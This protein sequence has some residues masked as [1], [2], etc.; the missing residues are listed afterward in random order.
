MHKNINNL[1]YS[2]PKTVD[3]TE[4][5]ADLDLI[6]IPRDRILSVEK[7]LSSEDVYVVFQASRILTSWG[8]NKGFGILVNFLKKEDFILT[9]RLHGYDETPQHIL[10]AL[11]RYWIN[12]SEVGL[13]YEAREKIQPYIKMII[14]MASQKG[15]QL[16]ILFGFIRTGSLTEYL[17]YLKNYLVEIMEYPKENKWKI[18][19]LINLFMQIHMMDFVNSVLDKS[20]Y[21]LSD[22]GVENE[23]SV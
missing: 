9:H 13:D 15:T 22:F 4:D 23:S 12:L 6:D 5:S 19:D 20:K 7:L 11:I 21:N 16:N 14:L 18:H 8:N 10:D 2:I 1:I 3:Y 17:P